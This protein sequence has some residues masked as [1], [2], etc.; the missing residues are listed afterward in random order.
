MAIEIIRCINLMALSTL[1]KCSME[2][3]AIE[4]ISTIKLIVNMRNIANM[5]TI[6]E[7]GAMAG[8]DKVR[9]LKPK[10]CT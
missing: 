3:M 1:D 10:L 5:G 8:E 7:V 9:A 2:T 6:G 4:I